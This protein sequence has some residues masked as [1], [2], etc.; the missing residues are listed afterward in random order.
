MKPKNTAAYRTIEFE[1][2]GDTVRSV[3]INGDIWFVAR[4]V[5]AQLDIKWSVRKLDSIPEDWLMNCNIPRHEASRGH[6][7]RQTWLIKEPALYMLAG[8]SNHPD[9]IG[10]SQALAEFTKMTRKGEVETEELDD[11][12]KKIQYHF[13]SFDSEDWMKDLFPPPLEIAK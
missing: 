3:E 10:F 9:A 7:P 11:M 1:L 5:L 12:R 2:Q 13:F 4:D 6:V 8:R